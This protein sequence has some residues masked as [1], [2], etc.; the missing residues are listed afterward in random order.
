MANLIIPAASYPPRAG[1]LLP[2]VRFTVA[3]HFWEFKW[4]SSP[5]VPGA[6]FADVFT[7]SGAWG[8]QAIAPSGEWVVPYPD[9]PN[10]LYTFFFA[11]NA[12]NHL[13]HPINQTLTWSRPLQ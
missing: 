3:D 2:A 5:T 7:P 12:V 4:S 11:T 10:G 9:A 8:W 13:G 1:Q 6:L